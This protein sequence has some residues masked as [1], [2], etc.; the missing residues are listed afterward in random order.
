MLTIV[1]IAQSFFIRDY[2]RIPW[3]QHNNLDLHAASPLAFDHRSRLRTTRLQGASL[4]SQGDT[5]YLAPDQQS[6]MAYCHGHC[7][8]GNFGVHEHIRDICRRLALRGIR[9]RP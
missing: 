8:A 4:S 1:N 3:Q 5:A 9:Y 2:G 7:G 6:A